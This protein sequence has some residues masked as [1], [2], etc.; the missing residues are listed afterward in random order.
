MS[1]TFQPHPL[2]YMNLAL[3]QPSGQVKSGF[4]GF[5]QK[6]KKH[7]HAPKNNWSNHW[8]KG[9]SEETS[10]EKCSNNPRRN[11]GTTERISAKETQEKS[12]LWRTPLRNL[13]NSWRNRWLDLQRN[14]RPEPLKKFLG[15]SLKRISEKMEGES[16][17]NSLKEFFEGIPEEILGEISPRIT[18]KMAGRIPYGIHRWIPEEISEGISQR[19]PGGIPGENP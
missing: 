5:H 17:K 14:C 6:K 16:L 7:N 8:R 15:K 2:R 3:I 12:H 9:I 10:E 13:C 11:W 19:I 4:L 1:C 18:E